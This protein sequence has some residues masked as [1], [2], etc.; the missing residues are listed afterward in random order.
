MCVSPLR[1]FCQHALAVWKWY[2]FLEARAPPGRQVVRINM[3]ETPLKYDQVRKRKGLLAISKAQHKKQKETLVRRASLALRRSVITL[4]AFMCDDD[5]IQKLL[6]QVII[7]NH[8]LLPRSLAALHRERSDSVYVLS[9]KT[10][11]NHAKMQCEILKLL[12]QILSPMRDSHWFIL[13]VDAHGAHIHPSVFEAAHRAGLM[14]LVIPASMT[15]LLQPLDTHIFSVFKYQLWSESQALLLAS[16]QGE[17]NPI[18]FLDMA[19]RVIARV[20]G[21]SNKRAFASCGFS[22]KQMG[23]G[24]RVL[25]ALEWTEVPVVS[26]EMPSLAELQQCWPDGRHIPIMSVFRAFTARP[27]ASSRPD[28]APVIAS[29]MPAPLTPPLR[30]RLRSASRLNSEIQDLES[31][32]RAIQASAPAPDPAF[33]EPCPTMSAAASSSSHL[34]PHLLPVGRPLLP[35]RLRSQSALSTS[36][37]PL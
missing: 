22:E 32:P 35:R 24:D 12:G 4:V 33:S 29:A 36:L 3:D 23:L 30:M 15:H 8:R 37:P 31:T 11:W 13:S 27:I 6:P 34:P 26:S 21:C 17:F 7:G 5:D 2:N 14:Q 10:G 28:P 9:R 25:Q 1:F 20:M 18:A 16:E 19:C